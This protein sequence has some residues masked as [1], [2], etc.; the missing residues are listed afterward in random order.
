MSEFV[1]HIK[2]RVHE[3]L[4]NLVRARTEDDDFAVQV[5]MGELESFARLAREHGVTIAGLQ[6]FRAA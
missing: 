4:S 6:N 2:E 1:D 5:H 3:A